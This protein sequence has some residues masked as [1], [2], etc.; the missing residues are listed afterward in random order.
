MLNNKNPWLVFLVTALGVSMSS[1]DG[2]IVNVALPTI[3]Q[4]IGHDNILLS[5][6]VVSGYLFVICVFLPLCGRLGDIYSRRTLYFSAFAIF[7]LSSLACGFAT[8]LPALI[9][10]RYVQGLGAAILLANNQ[11]LIISHIPKERHGQALG[12]NTMFAAIGITFGPG[13]GGLILNYFNWQSIFFVN[14]PIGLLG[15]IFCYLVLKR[16]QVRVKEKLDFL[17]ASLFAI[18]M[19]MLLVVLTSNHLRQLWSWQM[20]SFL[21]IAI[22]AG[23]AFIIWERNFKYPMID[24][25]VFRSK[26]FLLGAGA[27]SI[28]AIVLSMN[29]I[30]LPFYLDLQLH[31][32]MVV[33]GGLMLLSPCV[34][35]LL[36]PLCGYFADHKRADSLV[37]FGLGSVLVGLLMQAYL[38]L[39]SSLLYIAISQIAIGIGF[40]MFQSPNNYTIMS[41]LAMKRIGIGNSIASLMRTLGR[42][43]GVVVATAIFVA[44]QQHWLIAQTN[45]SA[46]FFAGFKTVLLIAVGLTACAL[47]I[48]LAKTKVSKVGEKVI[49]VPVED[50]EPLTVARR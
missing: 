18:A 38:N 14:I 21:A 8:S 5:Q 10:A 50:V 2:G 31:L 48:S 26:T 7:T 20:A 45:K 16:E 11:A 12:M 25:Q 4:Q 1:L 43:G 34:T 46:A 35:I 37:T 39:H 36:A 49:S 6:W 22:V 9:I 28:A 13:L 17:G 40:G 24:F 47:V 32:N 23:S 44:V 15:C 42:I 3:T 29:N 19:G 27:A 33:I 30:L 41:S